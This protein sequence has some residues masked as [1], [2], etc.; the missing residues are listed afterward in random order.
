VA[1]KYIVVEGPIGVGKTSLARILAEDFS[2]DLELDPADRNEFLRA[3]YADPERHALST[4]LRFLLLRLEQQARIAARP[5]DARNVVCDYLWVKDLIFAGLTLGR[6][7]LAL[8]RELARAAADSVHVGIRKPDLVVYLEARPE[9]L[10]QRLGKRNRDFER[11]IAP[12]Y[13]ESLTEA[14]RKFFHSYEEA[15]LLVV[16]SSE[17]DFLGNGDELVDLIREIRSVRHGVQHYI[18]L[19]SR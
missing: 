11:H 10:L 13:L 18:P 16:N 14:Y 1:G 3:F 19:G 9:V 17:I 2:A 6:D 8:Y 15:P 12:E 4:Q 5:E 7:E